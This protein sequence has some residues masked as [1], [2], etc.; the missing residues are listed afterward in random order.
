MVGM[1]HV[2]ADME[3]ELGEDAFKKAMADLT[4]FLGYAAEPARLERESLGVKVLIFLFILFW[5]AYFLKKEYWKDV[6]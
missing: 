2:L 6:H 4:N 1:P 5:P 3:K